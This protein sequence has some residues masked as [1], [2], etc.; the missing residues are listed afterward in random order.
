MQFLF[1]DLPD[2][3]LSGQE[4]S[5]LISFAR[6]PPSRHY[7]RMLG[8]TDNQLRVVMD[9]ATTVPIEKRYIYLERSPA[10]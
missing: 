3:W 10:C 4:Q 2:A 8:L 1:I 7:R 9:A 6:L 5:R